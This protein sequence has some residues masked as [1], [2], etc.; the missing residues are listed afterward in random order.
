MG[1]PPIQIKLRLCQRGGAGVNH[2]VKPFPIFYQHLGHQG[3]SS[4]PKPAIL[5][6][7]RLVL[8]L[9]PS[10]TVTALSYQRCFLRFPLCPSFWA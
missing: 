3:N 5:P 2:G 9:F 10:N 4:M 7:L 6:T 1:L 8:S